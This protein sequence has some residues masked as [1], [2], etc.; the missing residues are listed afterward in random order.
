MKKEDKYTMQIST[1]HKFQK[2]LDGALKVLKFIWRHAFVLIVLGMMLSTVSIETANWKNIFLTISVAVLVDFLKLK[3][4]I[5]KT[6]SGFNN[7]HDQMFEY[8][9]RSRDSSNFGSSAWATNPAMAGS[10]AN[11]LNNLGSTIPKYS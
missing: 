10:P 3:I 2:S 8:A 11:S 9:R 6:H 7:A 1:V 4:K 5:S